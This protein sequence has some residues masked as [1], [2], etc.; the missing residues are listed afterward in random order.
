MAI[1]EML[2]YGHVRGGSEGFNVPIGA[3]EVFSNASGRFVKPD[4]AN[5]RAELAGDAD[6]ELM[7]FLVCEAF[8]SSATE[9]AD[10][11]FC[12]NDLTAVFRIPVN[13][14]T[15]AKTMI[16]E[17]CDLSISSNIQGAQLNAS[18]ED[19]LIVVGGDV[20]NNNWVDVMLNP[21]KMAAVGVA[22]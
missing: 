9:G 10:E 4:G 13:A 17:T 1:G 20:D 3:S 18:D 15:Y 8:T 5:R 6:T 12:I 16:G 2:K 7:G 22:T 19:T 11:R 21:N 14:G